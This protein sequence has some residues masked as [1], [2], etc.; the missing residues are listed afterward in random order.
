MK[1]LS[2]LSLI[3]VLCIYICLGI[4]IPIQFI[5]SDANNVE[6]TLIV[7]R[8]LGEKQTLLTKKIRLFTINVELGT[9]PQLFRLKLSTL[10]QGVFIVNIKQNTQG[11]SSK[12]SSSFQEIKRIINDYGVGLIATDSFTISEIGTIN[13]FPFILFDDPKF[14]HNE[15]YSGILGLAYQMDPKYE[16]SSQGFY[17]LFTFFENTEGRH[18]QLLGI[19]TNNVDEGIMYIGDY[20]AEIKQ[21]KKKYKRCPIT[22]S[23]KVHSWRCNINAVYFDDNELMAVNL[24]V[25]FILGGNIIGVNNKVYEAIKDKY[26]AKAIQENLCYLDRDDEPYVQI[27]C[28]PGFDRSSLGVLSL[29]FGKWAL[30]LPMHHLFYK[31]HGLFYFIILTEEFD[32][33][34]WFISPT[35]L[36]GIYIFLDKDNKELGFYDSNSN[37]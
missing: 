19:R 35:M 1:I 8:S 12:A 9:P 3:I 24:P 11:F 31:L 25:D 34:Y 33:N 13:I 30:K 20:P 28:F 37:K 15:R 6:N 7:G 21:N 4:E 32:I 23:D 36:Y 27:V 2:S 26:F 22:S 10:F 18:R 29:V 14:S 17:D 5:D 16:E